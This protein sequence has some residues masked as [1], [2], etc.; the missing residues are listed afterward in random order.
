MDKY[1]VRR[2]R[3]KSINFSKNDKIKKEFTFYFILING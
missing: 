1:N 2:I 3:I